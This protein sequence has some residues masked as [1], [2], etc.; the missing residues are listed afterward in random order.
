MKKGTAL[1]P[2]GLG[3]SIAV[4]VINVLVASGFSITGLVAP[5]RMLAPGQV[6]NEAMAMF[7]MYAAARTLPLALV[8]LVL[9]YRRW[10]PGLVVLGFLAG[11]IQLLDTAIGIVEH[12][13]GKTFGPL[14]IALLQFYATNRLWRATRA[15]V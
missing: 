1:S 14:A 11:L 3:L 4:T 15:G 8:T 12:D 10:A 9:A 2:K 5:G 7:A 13:P 6:P